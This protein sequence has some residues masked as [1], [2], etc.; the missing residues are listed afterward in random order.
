MFWYIENTVALAGL[1]MLGYFLSRLI[2]ILFDTDLT[3]EINKPKNL[4]NHG[5]Q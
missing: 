3:Y 2:E 5:N 1:F 4:S